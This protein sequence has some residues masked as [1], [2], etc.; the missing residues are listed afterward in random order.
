MSKITKVTI[1]DN[2]TLRLDQDAF[3]G[4]VIDILSLET[5]DTSIISKK[6]D[7]AKDEQ[8]NLRLEKV[9]RQV[10]LEKESEYKTIFYDKDNQ[11]SILEE[12]LKSQEESIKSS[13]SSEFKIKIN[14]LE[15]Q[16]SQLE[17]EKKRIIE[18][19]S[20]EIEHQVIKNV[21]VLKDEINTY[22]NKISELKMIQENLV[23]ENH[24][25][26]QIEVNDIESKY[27]RIIQEKEQQISKL[28][29][30]KSNLNIKQM[31]EELET[32]VD[33]E[34]QH[35]AING[36]ETCSWEKDNEV[37]KSYG[38][39]KGSKADYVFK[40]FSDIAKLDEQL[41]TSVAIEIKSE[42]PHSIH[43]KKNS[44]HYDKLHKDR[45]KKKCEYALLIS[46][47]EWTSI[48]DAP[49]RKIP[50]YDKMY[51]VRPLYFIVF[52]NLIT[53]LALKYKEYLEAEL[54][55]EI[56]FKET[57]KIIDDFEEMKNDILDKSISY[58]QSKIDEISES[59]RNIKKDAE[60]IIEASRIVA[61]RH[62]QTVINKIQGFKLN[63]IIDEIN[64]LDKEL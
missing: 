35:Y 26:K 24:Y 47:L 15:N 34:F 29:L 31:G 14:H 43:K 25:Q 61:E 7:E 5:I 20:S 30:E 4:D 22:K 39:N 62:I 16:L 59:A 46:E 50:N 55:R 37:I 48:N 36:F 19:Q 44:D 60:K 27:Q 53:S 45:I 17:E 32:W 6:I 8:Y 21:A 52:L 56:R 51:M 57:R 28:S 42:D 41:L 58:I 12:R 33:Q 40:V 49:I 9:R 1:L 64:Q 2:H 11:I 13:I 38:E 63:Q 54:S 23:R 3:K 10:E 18:N